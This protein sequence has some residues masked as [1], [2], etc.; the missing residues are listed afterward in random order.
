MNDGFFFAFL[1]FLN[2]YHFTGWMLELFLNSKIGFC[3]FKPVY[4]F[5]PVVVPELN[6]I[7]RNV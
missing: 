7:I 1:L 3:G 4:S 5:Y 2:R 6:L